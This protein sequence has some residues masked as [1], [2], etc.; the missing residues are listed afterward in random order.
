MPRLHASIPGRE[1]L[2]A[3]RPG[4][5]P[6]CSSQAGPAALGTRSMVG[7]GVRVGIPF[8]TLRSPGNPQTATAPTLSVFFSVHP[9]GLGRALDDDK[10]GAHL[11]RVAFA[12]VAHSLRRAGNG[13]SFHVAK[14]IP[15]RVI[16]PGNGK[17]KFFLLGVF[18][19]P[20]LGAFAFN[21]LLVRMK[22]G[23]GIC[24]VCFALPIRA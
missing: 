5:W 9:G 21:A 13:L 17:Y 24:A 6:L 3:A 14:A 7:L 23:L 19:L 16:N 4:I 12:Q 15:S 2:Q 8:C 18:T 1:C 11:R 10:N 22:N 20:V